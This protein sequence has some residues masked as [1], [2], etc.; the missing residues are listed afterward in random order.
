MLNFF[1]CVYILG[2]KLTLNYLAS[3]LSMLN[4]PDEMLFQK[5]VV[6]TKFDIYVFIAVNEQ[7]FYFSST[8]YSYFFYF[9]QMLTIFNKLHMAI[10]NFLS[11]L[12]GCIK[13]YLI[14]ETAVTFSIMSTTHTLKWVCSTLYLYFQRRCLMLVC[15]VGFWYNHRQVRSKSKDE[16]A[17]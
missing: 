13:Q 8:F 14:E 5:R 6:C 10:D 15:T 1:L 11:Y 7:H 3:N 4:L 16:E 17:K 2:H 9:Y 12:H